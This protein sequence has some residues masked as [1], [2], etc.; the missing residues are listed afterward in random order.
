MVTSSMFIGG[1]LAASSV[2]T[3][4]HIGITQ[5]LCLCANEIGQSES[6]NPDLFEYKSFYVSI[7]SVSSMLHAYV[8]VDT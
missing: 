6:Q 1:A 3:L 4:Q 2:H 8:F 5:I 7:H